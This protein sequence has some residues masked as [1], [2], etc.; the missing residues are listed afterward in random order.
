VKASRMATT[1]LFSLLLIMSLILAACANPTPTAAPVEKPTEAAPAQEP[2]EPPAAVATEAPVAVATEAPVA[3]ATEA[4]T[5]E[6]TEAPPEEQEPQIGQALIGELE[7]PEVIT[8][9][10]QFPAT[11]QEA[12]ELADLVQNGALP[13]VEE[14]IG[15]D[16]L[17]IK[18]LHEIG[19]YGGSLRRG[20]TGPA[21]TWNG[22]RIAGYDLV[23]FWNYAADQV[24]P[25]IAKD[26]EM[27]EDGKSLTLYLREG[28]RWSDGEL[29][30]AD[31]FVFWYE[32]MYHNEEL[33]PT[34]AYE[35][36]ING[37]PVTLQK[38]DDYTVR[39]E[40]PEPYYMFPEILAGY[41]KAP[42]AGQAQYGKSASGGF[43]PAHY[44]KQFHPKYA[45]EEELNQIIADGGF[46]NWV[47]LFKAKNNWT[48]N[49]ELP[50]VTPWKVVT[51]ANSPVWTLE[52]NPYS[53]WVDTAGNQ[54][55][56]IDKIVLTLAENLEV[57]NL[58]A[59][60]GEY[61]YQSRHI[62]MGK[63]P[64]L[65]QN[66]E[67]GGYKVYLDPG[68]FGSDAGLNINMSYE[69]DPEIAQWLTNRDFRRALSL[70]IERDQLNE[71]F[72]L[73]V[74]TSGSQ[75][76]ADSN[77]YNPGPEYRT[78]WSTY[79]PET[80]NAMLDEI[81]LDQKDADGY[82]LRTDGDGRL[83]L[84]IL[85]YSG[86]FMPFTQI[87]E[88]IK[89]Q[90]KEIGIWADCKE[91]ERSLGGTIVKANE[92][93][94]LMWANDGSEDLFT[95]RKVFPV[96]TSEWAST[97]PLYGAWYATGGESGKE[98]PEAMRRAMEMFRSA[99]GVTDEERVE[100]G[101]EIWRI[102]ADEVWYISTVGLSPATGGVRV[103]NV[104]LGNVPSRQLTTI[105]IRTP[106]SSHPETFYW[107]E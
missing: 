68:D 71:T 78:L 7:G 77:K 17:V 65:V 2:T 37:K 49:T 104:K 97:G 47:S 41:N 5:E 52:R 107:K 13:P 12:P 76:P 20:F 39:Y 10:A 75:V 63:L 103:A 56:Y 57:I 102:A 14:R 85:T 26:W 11:F 38:V 74:G 73:G 6:P 70:G 1:W 9:P 105:S 67:T 59:I 88:M 36:T 60:A 46:D 25:N 64:V 84:E 18:P 95:S 22:S 43:A 90:W 106:S 54:L 51:P 100:M 30:T 66:Q 24:V 81:G 50:V 96:D 32:D 55:P 29:F 82:R 3:V 72:W 92:H 19:K 33:V 31:D 98:P 45:S 101:K 99:S 40:F 4:P 87:C 93:Q 23:L 69:L 8:D 15:K 94:F 16:P 48:L 62:D 86:Q 27:A 58:R 28:M 89:E 44:L 80:A 42:G 21:D 53:I 35:M 83:A 34:P 61:D 91:V 79:D